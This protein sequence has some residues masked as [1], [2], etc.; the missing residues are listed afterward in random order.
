MKKKAIYSMI[1]SKN[2]LIKSKSVTTF[3]KGEH[4]KVGSTIIII[5]SGGM[6]TK[7]KPRLGACWS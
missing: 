5:I 2:M 4:N 6:K 1:V 7:V 3:H